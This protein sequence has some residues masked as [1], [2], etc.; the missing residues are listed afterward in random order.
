MATPIITGNLQANVGVIG[1]TY[2]VDSASNPIMPYGSVVAG[3]DAV[4]GFA[5]FVFLLG[6]AS[7]AV[8]SV[9]T[10][11]EAGVTAL[12][13]TDSAA[14]CLGPVAVALVANTDPARGAWYAITGTFPVSLVASVADNALLYFCSTGGS[15][16]DAATT[17]R[18]VSNIISRAATTGAAVVNCQF[19]RPWGGI[20]MS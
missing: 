5:E 11:D 13:D 19:S 9:V 8:G 7:T 18:Q 20:K 16:D 15:L 12:A 14:T 6:V 3:L 2:A 1:V 10:Y 4:G 17:D